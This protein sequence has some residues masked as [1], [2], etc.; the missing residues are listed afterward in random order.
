MENES[1]MDPAAAADLPETDLIPLI[2]KMQQQLTNL[3]KKI[4]MLV[5]Q[6]QAKPFREKNHSG[7][8]FRKSGFSK[9]SHSFDRPRYHGKT[10]HEHTPGERDSTRKHFYDRYKSEN[11]R[12]A[13]PKKKP[14]YPRSKDRE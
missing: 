1:R 14:H 9:P 6:S 2:M 10:E 4:D 11:K 12:G 5:S 3:E 8:P 7:R 13:N